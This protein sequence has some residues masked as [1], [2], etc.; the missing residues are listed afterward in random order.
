[1]LM[2]EL[3]RLGACD[4]DVRYVG[5]TVDCRERRY[6]DCDDADSPNTLTLEMVFVLR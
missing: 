6:E 3:H 4:T 1:M 5:G 2:T